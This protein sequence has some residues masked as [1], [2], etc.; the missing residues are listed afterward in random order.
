MPKSRFRQPFMLSTIK[1]EK[2][3]KDKEVQNEEAGSQKT[4]NENRK[5]KWKNNNNK[6]KS[7]RVGTLPSVFTHVRSPLMQLPI[8]ETLVIV[9]PALLSFAFWKYYTSLA[10]CKM[11]E[12]RE[13]CS[14][15]GFCLHLSHSMFCNCILFNLFCVFILSGCSERYKS[16]SAFCS[17]YVKTAP[18]LFFSFLR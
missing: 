9:S 8:Q 1:K 7:N 4:T 16:L 5:A 2:K 18:V 15:M 10:F 12:P 6:K 14:C 3:I 11:Q 13:S 17:Q